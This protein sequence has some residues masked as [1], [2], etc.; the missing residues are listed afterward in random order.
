MKTLC[1]LM[2]AV[3]LMCGCVDANRGL[4]HEDGAGGTGAATPDTGPT[5]CRDGTPPP[6]TI[7]D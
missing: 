6:C 4:P 5:L 1:T 3:C 7:R 2:A